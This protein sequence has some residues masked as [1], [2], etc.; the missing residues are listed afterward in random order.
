MTGSGEEEAKQN[1]VTKVMD[2]AE[3]FY[4]RI[5]RFSMGKL[6]SENLHKI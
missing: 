6:R 5:C 3:I 4:G 1:A 2:M